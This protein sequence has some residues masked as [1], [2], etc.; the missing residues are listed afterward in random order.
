MGQGVTKRLAALSL[1]LALLF[2][3]G[4]AGAVELCEGRGC[5]DAPPV[6]EVRVPTPAAVDAGETVIPDLRIGDHPSSHYDITYDGGAWDNLGRKMVGARTADFFTAARS[7]T[8]LGI[9]GLHTVMAFGWETLMTPFVETVG[10]SMGDLAGQWGLFWWGPIAACLFAAALFMRGR[11]GA[12][13][14][15][16]VSSVACVA[17]SGVIIGNLAGYYQA[18]VALTRDMAVLAI[19]V[20][21]PD[22]AAG[23]EGALDGLDRSLHKAFV[24]DPWVT[25]NWGGP[26]AVTACAPAVDQALAEGPH[27][28]DDRPRVL[29]ATYG[30]K[31]DPDRVDTSSDTARD[32]KGALG[33]VKTVASG[34]A[35]VLL[36]DRDGAGVPLGEVRGPCA[37]A[38]AFNA[39]PTG[40]RMA[41]AF[42]L[43]VAS[44]LVFVLL[45][46]I[47]LRH[48]FRIVLVAFGFMILPLLLGVAAFPGAARDA[49][50]R[51]VAQI[52]RNLVQ[53][54][55]SFVVLG[56][57]IACLRAVLAVQVG[58]EGAMLIRFGLAVAVALAANLLLGKAMAATGAAVTRGVG[59]AAVGSRPSSAPARF[60][61][62]AAG[63]GIMGAAAVRAQRV[64]TARN[65]VQT[66]ARAARVVSAVG[67]AAAGAP[68]G[69]VA[70]VQ[71]HGGTAA[72]QARR[73]MMAQP[74]LAERAPAVAR[75]AH[76][77]QAAAT[78]AHA[79]A[80][81][82]PQ[83]TARV[84]ASGG[85]VERMGQGRRAVYVEPA[86]D[87]RRLARMSDAVGG[88]LFRT[89]HERDQWAERTEYRVARLVGQI[90]RPLTDA[91]FEPDINPDRKN[92]AIARSRA[93]HQQLAQRQTG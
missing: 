68:A 56:I 38:A 6:V 12:A 75:V 31:V 8:V 50:W 79:A 57:V 44:L 45:L 49:A 2:A 18:A 63:A 27:D 76:R 74:N 21:S 1:L 37:A 82:S 20:T 52:A 70:L 26:A 59:V 51:A 85:G 66:V 22:P 35:G 32:V 39:K 19:T 72:T 58:G 80:N 88:T 90:R 62:T 81:T 33:L 73:V 36:L 60:A 93:Y 5:P 4:G 46:R 91:D 54:V 7:I 61:V 71:Q 10:G 78:A 64:R 30:T 69:A 41:G 77:A 87:R 17:V 84:V 34:P 48:G 24:E 55:G 47:A 15:E 42:L 25:L 89:V 40:D 16:V 83:P 3:G 67:S 53:V 28:T 65:T 86:A 23:A 14:G 13:W 43:M 11:V 9:W 92:W 29:V